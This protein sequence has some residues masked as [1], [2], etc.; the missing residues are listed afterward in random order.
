MSEQLS[1]LAPVRKTDRLFFALFPDAAT[2]GHLSALAG[3]LRERHGLRGA[4][5]APGRFHITLTHLGDYEGLPRDLVAKAQEA[6]RRVA[7]SPVIPRF[8]RAGSFAGRARNNPFVLLSSEAETPV[9]AFQRSLG[10]AMKAT[11]LGHKAGPYS[12]HVTL[13]YD[14]AAIAEHPVDPVSWTAGEFVLVHSLLGQTK[15]VILDRWALQGR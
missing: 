12:P 11:G 9:T 4:P 15:H 6:G 2:A 1:L 8:D 5:L 10:E 3:E 13:L 7:A 14:D